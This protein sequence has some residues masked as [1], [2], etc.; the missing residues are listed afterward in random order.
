MHVCYNNDD[1]V[2]NDN[3]L[4]I[5]NNSM[6]KFALSLSTDLFHFINMQI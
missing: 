3:K 1:V 2:I 4:I 6:D 5:L